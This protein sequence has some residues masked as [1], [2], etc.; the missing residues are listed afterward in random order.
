LEPHDVVASKLVA[1]RYEDLCLVR[2][3]IAEGL[4]DTGI[5]AQR[6]QALPI[7]EDLRSRLLN[8]LAK[9]HS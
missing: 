4:I 6:V 8:W 2:A 1:F 9:R 5:L 7:D 3:L